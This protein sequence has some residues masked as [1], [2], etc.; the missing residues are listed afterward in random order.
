MGCFISIIFISKLPPQA[1]NTSNIHNL[2]LQYQ[3]ITLVRP[4]TLA[5]GKRKKND[6]DEPIPSILEPD[7][8]F[9]KYRKNWSGLIQKKHLGLWAVKPRPPPRRTNASPKV[10]KTRI[11][12]S[13]S[14]FTLPNKWL[15]AKGHGFSVMDPI[16][17]EAYPADISNWELAE[18]TG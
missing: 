11:D 14:E 6:Q 5:R 13:D 17:R 9:K 1:K 10:M 12:Y 8:S 7:G 15:Y 16:Y 2:L 4:R 3:L 18:F